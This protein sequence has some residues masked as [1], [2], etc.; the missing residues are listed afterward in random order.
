MPRRCNN[1]TSYQ[2]SIESQR[3]WLTTEHP[4][5]K[6]T[7]REIW[8]AVENRAAQPQLIQENRMTDTIPLLF[9]YWLVLQA[10]VANVGNVNLQ[11]ARH[12]GH[13]RGLSRH[14]MRWQKCRH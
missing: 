10:E 12:V 2:T 13:K 4:E 3:K 7:E 1:S 11:K 8:I 6:K 5:N 9:D 14:H